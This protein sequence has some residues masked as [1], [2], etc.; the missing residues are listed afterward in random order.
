M[1]DLPA[2]IFTEQT[3]ID[4]DTLA[5]LGPLRALAG[6]WE[7]TKGE[8]VN[9]NPDETGRQA[10]IERIT[11]QP[12]DPQSNGPQLLYGLRYHT[13]VVKPGEVDTYHDQVGYWSWEPATG[14]I[15]HSL[16]IPRGQTALAIGRAAPGATRFEVKA[17]RGSTENGISSIAFLEQA[18]RTDAFI[19]EV[20]VNANGTWSYVS[21]TILQVHGQAEPFH[22]TDRNTLTK[23]AE[24]TPNPMAQIV[25]KSGQS[26]AAGRPAF[27]WLG[28]RR[29]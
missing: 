8:D 5:N 12:I 16:T 23:I 9:P 29:S 3:D 7:G 21:D 15:Y 24:P 11:L 18:F 1:T 28:R 10:Y 25:S 26:P 4:P 19:L 14:T 22:H 17:V 27:R 13:H 6:V 20:T 2:D